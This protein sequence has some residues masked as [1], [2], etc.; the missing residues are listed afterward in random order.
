MELLSKQI[1]LKHLV[2]D[3]QRLIGLKFYPDKVIHA[4]IKNLPNTAWST[5]FSMVCMPYSKQNVNLIFTAFKSIAWL[6]CSSFF[7]NKP[8]KEGQEAPDVNAYRNR[9]LTNDYR[10][11][12]ES[13]LQKLE[14]KKYANNTVK[15]YIS[16]FE[17]FINH[18]KDKELI[19]ID[20]NDI[21]LYLQ[22]LVQLKKSDSYINQM[23]NSIKFYYEIVLGMPNRFYSI[24]RPRKQERLPEILAK[25]EVIGII[26]STANI[27][28]K[29]I[30]SL[31]YSAGLRRS[32]LINLKLD[33]I[34][35][36]RM[37][38]KI[39]QGK[40]R[41]DRMTLLS[42]TLL[43]ELRKYFKLY[44]PKTYLFEGPQSEKYSSSSVAKIVSRA[45]RKAGINKHITPHMLRH[46]FA[47]HLLEAG[48]D[49]RYI[50]V[51]LGHS[52][53]KTTE[54]YTQVAVNT[55]SKII[56]PLDLQ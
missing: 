2:I 11:C 42:E 56:N 27:K 3:N 49:L 36:K 18:L 29:C 26:N 19:S 10:A 16:C 35:S 51:L 20:E 41:K 44:K 47:T 55:F 6:N 13:Y 43:I 50:Q 53:S 54:I 39:N 7:S 24:E 15:T 37:L 25:E 52:S 23:I 8:M 28:H 48:T 30:I 34:N 22:E 46:S 17:Q 4:L 31:L 1:A 38:I 12:P 9:I 21:R 45:A 32:E 14:L 33:D 5:K 40:G